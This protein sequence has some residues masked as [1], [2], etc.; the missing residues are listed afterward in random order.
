MLAVMSLLAT[1][2]WADETKHEDEDVA[3]V[4]ALAKQDTAYLTG[5]MTV[6]NT[7]PMLNTVGAGGLPAGTWKFTVNDFARE[8]TQD[9]SCTGGSSITYRPD[10]RRIPPRAPKAA[11]RASRGCAAGGHP[12]Q[13]PD[14]KLESRLTGRGD[15]L[16][17]IRAVRAGRASPLGHPSD[18]PTGTP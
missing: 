18:R 4:T 10:L 7:T 16:P 2:A 13:P 14:R 5:A 9:S 1:T 8:C 3:F 11:S 15:L 17:D 6:P 12:H